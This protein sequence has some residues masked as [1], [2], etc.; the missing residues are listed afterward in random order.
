MQRRGVLV[1]HRLNQRRITADADAPAHAASKCYEHTGAHQYS[2]PAGSNAAH[3]DAKEL[4]YWTKLH[5]ETPQKSST[6]AKTA[7]RSPRTPAPLLLKAL[8]TRPT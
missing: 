8:A 3:G 7:D 4:A 6:A 2:G 5:K 1:G